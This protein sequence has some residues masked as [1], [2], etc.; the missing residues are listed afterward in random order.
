MNL[1]QEVLGLLELKRP[2]GCK[3]DSD[4]WTENGYRPICQD[5]EP[6]RSFPEQCAN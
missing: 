4:A 6:D 1:A 3:C 5:F 2:E